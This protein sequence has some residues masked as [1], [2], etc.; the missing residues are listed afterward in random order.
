M[1]KLK[2]SVSKAVFSFGIAGALLI[3]GAAEAKVLHHYEG[4]IQAKNRSGQYT[5]L[6]A[7]IA[8]WSCSAGADATVTEIAA[9]HLGRPKRMSWDSSSDYSFETMWQGQPSIHTDFHINFGHQE[10]R[11]E[12]KVWERCTHSEL[13]SYRD[14]DGK[15][16][17]RTKTDTAQMNWSCDF[18]QF[19]QREG[20]TL[21]QG[22]QPDQSSWSTLFSSFSL[23]TLLLSHF[24]QKD[25]VFTSKL[26]EV[27]SKVLDYNCN[28][29]T[30][31]A[32]IINLSEGVD[33]YV[34]ENDFIFSIR[35]N[36]GPVLKRE[37]AKGLLNA[38]VA[39]CPKAGEKQIK[40]EISAIEDDPDLSLIHI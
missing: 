12:V 32:K 21:V 35:L 36:G 9:D 38:D 1:L 3:P 28:G 24:K 19:P 13:E 11:Y 25:I 14:S 6:L 29:E 16:Q 2:S 23:N 15:W 8:G 30:G 31:T 26:L 4:F 20:Q 10:P 22:C 18:N 17:T 37:E 40:V 33:G 39:Y 5:D 34:F 27:K 7:G